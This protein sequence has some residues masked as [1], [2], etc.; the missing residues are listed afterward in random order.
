M[1][2][3]L[4]IDDLVRLLGRDER[5]ILELVEKEWLVPCEREPLSFDEEDAARARLICEMRELMG[6]NDESVPII[7]HL[8]DQIHRLRAELALT[9]LRRER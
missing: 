3:Y 4:A 1:S 9:R 6:V 5:L 7:L 8:L 2:R